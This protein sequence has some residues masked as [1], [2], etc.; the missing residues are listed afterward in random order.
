MMDSYI[1]KALKAKYFFS[2]F[3]SFRKIR[4]FGPKKQKKHMLYENVPKTASLDWFVPVWTR[5]NRFGLVLT[6]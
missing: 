6:G 3:S 5:L 1:I 4:Y 2:S